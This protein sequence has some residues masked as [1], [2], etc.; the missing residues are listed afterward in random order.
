MKTSYH[1]LEDDRLAVV[2]LTDMSA[3]LADQFP[4]K[5]VFVVNR[6][7]TPKEI[8]GRGLARKLLT[9]MTAD[10]DAERVVLMLDFQPYSGTDEGRL[11]QLYQ[12]FGFEFKP[13]GSMVRLPQESTHEYI[14]PAQ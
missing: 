11:L 14:L 10:A 9:A 12:K 8:R 6:V 2:D 4:D 3:I 7:N 5:T 1:H 13:D